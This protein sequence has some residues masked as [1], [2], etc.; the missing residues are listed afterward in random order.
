MVGPTIANPSCQEQLIDS[1]KEVSQAVDGCLEATQLATSDPNL[2]KALGDAAKGVGNA[3]NDLLSH[4][5]MVSRGNCSSLW[6]TCSVPKLP[7]V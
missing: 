5:K 3:L 6:S 7:V 2:L 1:A 4:I